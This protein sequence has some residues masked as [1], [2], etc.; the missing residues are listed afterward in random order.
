[1]SKTH[2]VKCIQPYFNLVRM[3]I[4]TFEV[5]KMDRDYQIGDHLNLQEYEPKF[6]NLTGES[7][8]VIILYILQDPQYCREGFGI[9]AI[10][11][12]ESCDNCRHNSEFASTCRD[13]VNFDKYEHEYAEAKKNYLLKLEKETK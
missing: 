1:M 7:C 13:C 3:G 9:L 10:E 4:K 2:D 6:Q 5:R 8:E 11:I 12:V